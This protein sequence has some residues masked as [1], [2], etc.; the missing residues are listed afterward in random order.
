MSAGQGPGLVVRLREV[1]QHRMGEPDLQQH[2]RQRF[3]RRREVGGGVE[4]GL[5]S[6]QCSKMLDVSPGRIKRK[7]RHVGVLSLEEVGVP[8]SHSPRMSSAKPPPILVTPGLENVPISKAFRSQALWHF[9]RGRILIG[10][11]CPEG[12]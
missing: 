1:Q 11:R 9:T 2:E 12:F 5:G 6:S 4:N 7:T 3:R 10:Q 8:V